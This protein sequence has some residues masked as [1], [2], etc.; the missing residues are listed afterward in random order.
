MKKIQVPCGPVNTVK[1][2]FDDPQ[3]KHREMEIIMD[4]NLSGSNN[5]NLIGSPIKM[6]STPVTYR[7]S[8]P[9]LGEHT[10]EILEELLGMN[11]KERRDLVNKGVV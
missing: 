10:D 7:Y 2:V 9:S 8:P 11:K 1:E 3:I 4:H 6:S 5:L